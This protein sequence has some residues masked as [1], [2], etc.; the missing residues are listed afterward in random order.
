MRK[1]ERRVKLDVL[2]K[3]W[4]KFASELPSSQFKEGNTISYKTKRVDIVR[5]NQLCKRSTLLGSKV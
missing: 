5:I 3:E 2:F 4:A 1:L